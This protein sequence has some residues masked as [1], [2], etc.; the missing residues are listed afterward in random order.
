M[1]FSVMD[2]YEFIM[3]ELQRFRRQTV[4]PLCYSSDRGMMED[5]H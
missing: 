4:M 1:V 2:R 5:G 3:I